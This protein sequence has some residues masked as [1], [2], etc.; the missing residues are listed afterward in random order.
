V[1]EMSR[2]LIAILMFGFLALFI[3]SPFAALASLMLILLIG[4][5]FSLL[6]NI[7]QAILGIESD[8]Q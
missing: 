3:F 1:E 7:F 5:F 4:S 8:S 6:A 2:L